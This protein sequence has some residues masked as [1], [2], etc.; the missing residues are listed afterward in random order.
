MKLILK[1]EL[2]TTLA[3]FV[4][5]V[6]ITSGLNKADT[7]DAGDSLVHYLFSAHAFKYPEHFFNHWAK[8]FFVLLSAPFAQFGFKGI[9]VFNAL[10][11]SL[12]ALFS[13]YIARNLNIKNPLV[14]FVF[15][16]A[17]PL[18]FKLIFSGLTEYLFAL[19]LVIGI[20]LFQKNKAIPAVILI[21]FLPL[22]RSEGL[23]I[24]GVFAAYLALNNRYKKIPY[25]LSGQVVYTIAG[26]LFHKDILWVFSEI[27]YAHL[28]S[29]YGSGKLT[30]FIE[31]LYYT[32]ERPICTLLVLGIIATL[33]TYLTREKRN[34]NSIRMFLILGSFVTFFVAHSIFWWLGIFN[35][36]GLARVLICIVP[37]GAILSLAGLQLITDRFNNHLVKK[38]IV[39][40]FLVLICIYPFIDRPWAVV[41]DK[42]LFLVPDNRFIED[43]LAPYV[44]SNFPDYPDKTIYYSHPYISVALDL[45]YFSNDKY[46]RVRRA[47][48]DSEMTPAL[49]FWDEWFSRV[50]ENIA[51]EQLEGMKELEKVQ[52]FERLH[53]ERNMQLVVFKR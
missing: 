34:R 52:S 33:I 35:S 43:E 23:L 44:K 48:T 6:I 51:L 14:V 31:R 49:I 9:I 47:I 3:V 10:C 25:L 36:M 24:L 42:N 29:P 1:I 32:M 19:I 28:G 15:I 53:I 41:F 20:F 40:A 38:G 13:Y 5:L 39:G 2:L 11:A 12:S 4:A 50:D 17:S 18:Y 22:V 8:P 45:D 37:L 27:P 26:A 21:S 16:F 46:L 30:D 7:G